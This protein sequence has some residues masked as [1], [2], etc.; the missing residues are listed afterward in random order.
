MALPKD[1]WNR[2]RNKSGRFARKGKKTKRE[3]A[4]RWGTTNRTTKRYYKKKRR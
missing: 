3:V 1:K 2:Y 4:R